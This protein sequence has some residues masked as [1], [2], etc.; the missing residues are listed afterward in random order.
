MK[1]KGAMPTTE[2]IVVPESLA[3]RIDVRCTAKLRDYETKAINLALTVMAQQFAYEKPVIR[4][5]ALLAFIPGFTL[6]MSL[7]GDELGMTK[8]MFVFPL[9]QWREIA[10][11]DPDIPCFAVM[12]EM[13]H[14]FYGIADETEVKKKVVG[15]VRRFIK[16]SVTFEQVFPGWDCETSSLRSSTG[17][18]RPR[19]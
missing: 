12:E 3:D 16:Q 14:C 6:S 9:R 19:N 1:I 17:D 2:G 10:D 15:I 4:N 13:C 18:H 5:R 8:S 11:N 7:D